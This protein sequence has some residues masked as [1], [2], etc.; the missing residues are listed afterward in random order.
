MRAL[1]L[2]I[3]LLTVGTFFVAMAPTSTAVGYCITKV[4]EPVPSDPCDGLVCIG[5][6][7]QTG[8]QTCVPPE[9]YCLDNPCCYYEIGGSTYYYCPPPA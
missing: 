7:S 9:I 8:W 1:P 6:N 5:Y 3:G 4:K 2:A